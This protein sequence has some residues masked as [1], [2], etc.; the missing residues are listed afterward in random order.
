MVTSRHD[1]AIRHGRLMEALL[2][3]RATDGQTV[4]YEIVGDP[5]N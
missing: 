4:T 2:R 3:P 1:E 5:L